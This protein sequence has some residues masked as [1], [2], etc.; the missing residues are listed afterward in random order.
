[1]IFDLL[2]L[3]I[4]FHFPESLQL[5]LQLLPQRILLQVLT[6]ELLQTLVRLLQGLRDVPVLLLTH[7]NGL[8]LPGE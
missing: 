7:V 3:N 8:I 2:L 4:D 5:L 6:L 1:M